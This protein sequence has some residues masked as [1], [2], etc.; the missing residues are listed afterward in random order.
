[1][2]LIWQEI[3]EVDTS[4]KALRSFGWLVGG[5][6]LVIAL[7]VWWRHDWTFTTAIYWLGGIGGALVV[8]GSMVPVLLRPLYRVWMAL[9]IVLGFVMTRVLLTLVFF[10]LITPIGLVRRLFGKDPLRQK[11]DAD[12]TSYWIPKTYDDPSKERLEKYY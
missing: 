1:M 8:L 11:P 9:A 4:K 6:L 2:R 3:K 5:M 7:V 10:L 12:A